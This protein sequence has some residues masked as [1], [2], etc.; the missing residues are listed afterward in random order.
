MT[1]PEIPEKWLPCKAHSIPATTV[2][3]NSRA[4]PSTVQHKSTNLIH[5]LS[6]YHSISKW[7]VLPPTANMSV[8]HG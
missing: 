8:F 3:H 1:F 6:T 5:N 7:S 4:F 2:Q